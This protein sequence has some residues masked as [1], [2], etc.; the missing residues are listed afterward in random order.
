MLKKGILNFF[1][2][3]ALKFAVDLKN[4]SGHYGHCY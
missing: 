3:R 2:E 1:L 4:A